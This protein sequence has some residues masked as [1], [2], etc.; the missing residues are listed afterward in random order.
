MNFSEKLKKSRPNVLNLDLNSYGSDDDEKRG[1]FLYPYHS[2]EICVLFVYG[3]DYKR[4]ANNSILKK[5]KPFVHWKSLIFVFAIIALCFLRRMLK[6]RRDG[7]ISA[8]IDIGI[9][10]GGGGN[11]RIDNKIERM[12]FAIMFVAF[13]FLTALW[14]ETTL[15]PSFLIPHR[16][17]DTFN[18]LAE[19]N[20]PVYIS[21]KLKDK[22]QLVIGMLR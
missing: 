20:T 10:V 6:L 4:Q 11:L 12:F 13:F 14:L 22:E 1:T 9:V 18:E 5:L 2:T 17:I 21:I 16:T 7:L 19:V 15:Y 3:T 8:Y